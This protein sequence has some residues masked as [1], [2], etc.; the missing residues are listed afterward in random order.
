MKNLNLILLTIISLVLLVSITGAIVSHPASEIT[1]G[2]FGTG[3][4]TFKGLL[5]IDTVS[6]FSAIDFYDNGIN[7]WG[8]GKNPSNNF[9]IDLF[10]VGNALT[11][12]TNRNVGIGTDSPNAKLEVI[13]NVN[14]GGNLNLQNNRI[15]NV[16]DPIVSGDV[17][18]KG[19]VE[20]TVTSVLGGDGDGDGVPGLLDC[21]DGDINVWQNLIGYQDTDLDTY[22]TGSAQDVCSGNSLPSGWR[23]SPNAEDCNDN[24]LTCFPG[25][26]ATT[27]TADGKD[28]DCDG[29]VDENIAKTR[30]CGTG[31]A[32]EF[33]EMVSSCNDYCIYDGTLTCTTQL[34]GGG[35]T[36]YFTYNWASCTGSNVQS[37]SGSNN[38][39]FTCKAD[40][41]TRT[42]T[43]ED[44]FQ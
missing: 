41:G 40:T 27:P 18:T 10:E 34:Y 2:I 43:C 33:S 15:T 21:N 9:Y 32:V 39:C 19:F 1:A 20:A 24:C 37:C 25:S 35:S 30:V 44:A 29:T 13:G 8:I 3:D 22:T 12:D 16:A 23:S 26:T 17:A 42:C 5:N 31:T 38:N 6:S 14:I 11:I 28:Q 36:F 7:K 4:F